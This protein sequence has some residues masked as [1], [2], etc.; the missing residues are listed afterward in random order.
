[1]TNAATLNNAFI[2]ANKAAYMEYYENA[3]YALVKEVKNIDC[4]YYYCNQVEKYAASL[5]YIAG[6]QET[7]DIDYFNN[8]VITGID[9]FKGWIDNEMT[10]NGVRV[11]CLSFLEN[12]Q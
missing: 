4:D 3:A 8:R 9:Q 10:P 7:F 12:I 11:A 1:M 5:H 2:N 6:N